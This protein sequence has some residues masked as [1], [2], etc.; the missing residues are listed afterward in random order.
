MTEVV[1]TEAARSDLLDIWFYIAEE[2]LGAA[3]KTLDSL[4]KDAVLLS[5]QPLAGRERPD[6]G[7]GVR[8]WPSSTPYIMF[9]T[10]DNSRLIVIRVLHHARDIHDVDMLN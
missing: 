10:V 5:N 2:S 7:T 1:Y 8:S 3:D 9:Y 4:E 6:L